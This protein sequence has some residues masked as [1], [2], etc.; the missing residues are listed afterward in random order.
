[1]CL[2]VVVPDWK[3]GVTRCVIYILY[4]KYAQNGNGLICYINVERLM[5]SIPII[6][7]MLEYHMYEFKFRWLY[8]LL[9]FILCSL[10]VWEFKYSVLF[11]LCPINLMFTELYEGFSCF[12]WLSI[13]SSLVINLPLLCYSFLQFIVPGLFCEESKR[14]VFLSKL[15]VSLFLGLISMY[16]IYLLPLLVSFFIGFMSSNLICSIKLLDFCLFLLLTIYLSLFTLGL[17]LISV[18]LSLENSRKF[19]Y[20]LLLLTVALLTPPDVFSLLFVSVPSILFMELL[21][22]FSLLFKS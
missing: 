15:F 9:S 7:V 13:C 8:F 17:G 2:F 16:V 1:M 11:V 14:F 18:L 22:F 6:S 4:W 10:L 3:E 20:M 5:G 21:F 19:L 12:L